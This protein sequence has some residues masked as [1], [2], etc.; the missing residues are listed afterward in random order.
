MRRELLVL[1]CLSHWACADSAQE[2]ARAVFA[3]VSG[4]VH[5]MHLTAFGGSF[6]LQEY[7]DY[8]YTCVDGGFVQMDVITSETISTVDLMHEFFACRLA[9]VTVS[10][11]FDYLDASACDG[12]GF[13]ITIVGEL[14]LTGVVDG[15]CPVAAI[16]DCGRVAG[17]VCGSTI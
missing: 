12:G 5:E 1:S 13:D 15:S 3:Q 9:D 4:L 8:R 14:Q 6:S 2:D 11:T 7:R 10:G 17:S 16:E